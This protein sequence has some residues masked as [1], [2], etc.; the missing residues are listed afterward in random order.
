VIA[1][2]GRSA[3]SELGHDLETGY[4]YEKRE[5]LGIEKVDDGAGNLQTFVADIGNGQTATSDLHW[6]GNGTLDWVRGQRTRAASGNG[7]SEGR[8]APRSGRRREAL[9]RWRSR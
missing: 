9:G 6:N 5:F 1:H 3:A 8:G 2:D 7:S 4:R